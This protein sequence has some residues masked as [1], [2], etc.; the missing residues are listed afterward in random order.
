MEDVSRVVDNARRDHR[1]K[2]TRPHKRVSKIYLLSIRESNTE[3]KGRLERTSSVLPL[4]G[5]PMG[6]NLLMFQPL[7]YQ[8]TI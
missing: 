4:S 3:E 6:S 7:H 8:A 5:M 2:P 1:T